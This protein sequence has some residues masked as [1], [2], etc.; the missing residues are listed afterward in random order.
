[1]ISAGPSGP[2][3]FHMDP[4]QLGL[5]QLASP[6]VPSTISVVLEKSALKCR[7][8]WSL[9]VVLRACLLSRENLLRDGCQ[10][11]FLSLRIA[12]AQR[13][14][15]RK[16]CSGADLPDH[17]SL[18]EGSLAY[19]IHLQWEA[20]I[21]TRVPRAAGPRTCTG[22]RSLTPACGLSRR[23]IRVQCT[24][25]RAGDR[26]A[27]CQ[28]HTELLTELVRAR[29]TWRP[30]PSPV[31]PQGTWLPAKRQQLLERCPGHQVLTSSPPPGNQHD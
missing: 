27:C 15:T 25:Q 1:M 20:G 11:R 3:G 5:Q 12:A 18:A 4:Q 29:H 9:P 23:G 8:P 26:S 21:R 24:K 30:R 14:L 28:L 13:A 22:T 10:N 17:V 19:R 2:P 31:A 16:R 6:A 7:T